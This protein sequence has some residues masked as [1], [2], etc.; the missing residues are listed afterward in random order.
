M[1]TYWEYAYLNNAD[2]MKPPAAIFV[3]RPANLI[4][5]S[6]SNIFKITK[7]VSEKI[8]ENTER[9][10]LDLITCVNPIKHTRDGAKKSRFQLS[11]IIY[12]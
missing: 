4:S 9:S 7:I 11:N 1:I 6:E 2:F 12:Q 8:A 3:F 5:E 10:V